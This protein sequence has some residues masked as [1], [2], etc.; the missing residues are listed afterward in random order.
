MSDV[1]LHDRLTGETT[2]VSVDSAGR[3]G[4]FE[5]RDPSISTD[6]R[7]VTF[8]SGAKLAPAGTGGKDIFIHD[9]VT[10]KTTCAS[11][12]YRGVSGMFGWNVYP[13]ISGDGR[14]VVFN[15]M[16][17][18]L[19]PEDQNDEY[20]VF[21]RGPEVALEAEPTSIGPGQLLTLTEYRG[22]PGNLASLWVV[23]VNGSRTLMLVAT[24]NLA[25]DGNF[26]VSGIVPPGLSGQ[27]VTFRGYA[28]GHGG[29]QVRTN[30]VTVSFQ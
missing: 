12:L 4:D 11:V 13:S 16:D 24:G 22:V 23:S 10:R 15:G 19:V 2:R 20:D 25:G 1:F 26:V 5:S 8:T 7:Y 29:R 27:S 21:V 18:G 6:G 14:Y 9:R 30:D 17:P 28:V 3:Q